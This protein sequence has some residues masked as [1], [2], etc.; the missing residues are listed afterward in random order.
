MPHRISRLR[1][2]HPHLGEPPPLVQPQLAAAHVR[3]VVHLQHHVRAVVPADLHRVARQPDAPGVKVDR[4]VGLHDAPLLALRVAQQ[5]VH[6]AE[7]LDGRAAHAGDDVAQAR[8]ARTRLLVGGAGGLGDD[9]GGL[10]VAVPVLE[11]AVVVG[12]ILPFQ[13]YRMTA[14]E[15][16][17]GRGG[18]GLPPRVAVFGGRGGGVDGHVDLR[19]YWTIRWNECSGIAAEPPKARAACAQ[20]APRLAISRDPEAEVRRSRSG[21]C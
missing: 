14:G 19:G 5:Q 12:Q 21:R 4:L 6:G 13:G 10:G 2:V 8:Q 20:A 17:C 7:A 1:Y 11:A 3:G 18:D 9:P 16:R 15:L